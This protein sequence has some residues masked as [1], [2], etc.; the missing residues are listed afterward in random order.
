M[1][2]QIRGAL[3][4]AL[5]DLRDLARGIYPPLLADRGLASAIEAQARKGAVPTTV[6]ADGI[7]RFP[8]DIEAA[9][10]FCI[11]EALQNVAKY[12]D[13]SSATVVLRHDDGM[14]EFRVE[15]DG[16]GFDPANTARGSGL[17]GMGDRVDAIGGTITVESC[18]GAGTVVLGCV[19]T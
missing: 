14:L 19:R 12:A 16:R 6:T 15:D 3:G 11:L 5:D 2:E 1:T 10:Y 8:R 17:Q 13:A 9:V 4:E 7:G 18:P